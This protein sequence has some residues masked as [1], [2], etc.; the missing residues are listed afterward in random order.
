[1]IVDSIKYSGAKGKQALI[2]SED[3]KVLFDDEPGTSL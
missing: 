3:V 2:K 1:M